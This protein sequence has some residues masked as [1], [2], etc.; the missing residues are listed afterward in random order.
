[1]IY[2]LYSKFLQ[3][4]ELVQTDLYDLFHRLE[5]IHSESIQIKLAMVQHYL[6]E[7]EFTLMC[8]RTVREFYLAQ[9]TA[10]T[11]FL[12]QI[13]AYSLSCLNSLRCVIKNDVEVFHPYCWAFNKELWQQ[14]STNKKFNVEIIHISLELALHKRI[15]FFIVLNMVLTGL[16]MKC[17]KDWTTLK[18]HFME[19]PA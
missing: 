3:T 9:I 13:L 8:M 16:S 11:W 1:M 6:D 18:D 14:L 17:I 5:M 12:T 7:F 2:M 4:N 15:K 10:K 19:L